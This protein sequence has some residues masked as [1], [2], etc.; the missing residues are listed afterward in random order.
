MDPVLRAVS[1]SLREKVSTS[2]L[3]NSVINRFTSPE[4]RFST[5]FHRTQLP[6]N[7]F[8][9]KFD[10]SYSSRASLL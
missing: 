4:Q 2:G 6:R 5:T 10:N 3:R 8:I 1:G 7:D 9:K